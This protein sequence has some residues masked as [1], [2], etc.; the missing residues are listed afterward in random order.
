LRYIP[1]IPSLSE[2]WCWISS[3]AFAASIEMI[4]WFCL[5]FY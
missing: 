3:K 5:C 1:S 2:L 4:K